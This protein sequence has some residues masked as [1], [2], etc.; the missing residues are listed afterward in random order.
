MFKL[1]KN[2]QG[3]ELLSP[4]SHR[5]LNDFECEQLEISTS[6]YIKNVY[7]SLRL[8]HEYQVYHSIDYNRV[9]KKKCSYV[10]KYLNDTE[11]HFGEIKYFLK[12]E[13]CIYLAIFPLNII[14]NNIFND[15]KG[16]LPKKLQNLKNSRCFD[17]LYYIVEKT[18]DL[19]L[20]NSFQINCKCI[21][22]KQ[23]DK[24]YY[25]CEFLNENEHD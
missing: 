5:Q 21:I 3:T 4:I 12:I 10:I 16:R 15:I 13:D 22:F 9:S 14:S 8:Y 6:F 2:N 1:K 24:I 7:S 20:I 17:N 23:T 19:I 25:L 18:E 11:A